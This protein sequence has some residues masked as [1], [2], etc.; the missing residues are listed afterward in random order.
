[1]SLRVVEKIEYDLSK[2][3]KVVFIDLQREKRE[4]FL[5]VLK[6][7]NEKFCKFIL[8]GNF[9]FPKSFPIACYELTCEEARELLNLKNTY[10]FSG[11]FIVISEVELYGTL[12]NYIKTGI[13]TEEDMEIFF[14]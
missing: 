2:Y 5:E 10:E 11:N 8:Y 7:V 13:L 3:D 4:V 6:G 1:M 9:I 14:M 12:F